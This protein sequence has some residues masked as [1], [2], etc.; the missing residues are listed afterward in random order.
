MAPNA[1]LEP[2][3]VISLLA[4]GT[5]VNRNTQTSISTS[6][7]SSRESLGDPFDGQLED[8]LSRD[9][10]SDSLYK[11]ADSG[12]ISPSLLPDTESTWRRREIG[13]LSWKKRVISP[14]TRVY[15]GTLL[16]RI[17]HKFPFLVEAWYWALIY[18]V[19]R[20]ASNRAGTQL[21]NGDRYISSVEPSPLSVST[22]T[23]WTLPVDMPS[24]SSGSRKRWAFSGSCHCRL[25]S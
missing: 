10:S 24:T 12:P 13:I 17:L 9:S 15:R 20:Q 6:L 8:G 1:F 22:N 11:S 2:L 19:S 23:P 7:R 3:V 16:S 14:N 4:G 5:I 25:K 18:W 21:I